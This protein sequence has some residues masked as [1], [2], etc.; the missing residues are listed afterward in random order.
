MSGG[1]VG[2]NRGIIQS[3]NITAYSYTNGIKER[4]STENCFNN[5]ARV[6]GAIVGVNIGGLI[7]NCSSDVDVC[8]TTDLTT[9]GGIVGRNI[10]G[11]VYDCTVA[12]TI[13]AFFAGGVAGTDYTYK[14]IINARKCQVKQLLSWQ[15]PCLYLLKTAR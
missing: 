10:E 15:G 11:S 1:L 4:I 6:N 14:T 2:E 3:S 5:Y 8:A 13:E 12:G 9:A 7:N